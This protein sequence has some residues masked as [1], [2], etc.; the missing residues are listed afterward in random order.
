MPPNPPPQQGPGPTYNRAAIISSMLRYYTLLS[1]AV[2]IPASAIEQAPKAGRSDAS[3]PLQ[4]LL[5]LGFNDKMLD[6]IRHAPFL[7]SNDRPVYYSTCT[8]NYYPHLF[9]FPVEDYAGGDAQAVDMWPV[10]E[11]RVAEGFV[12]LARP[13]Q[14]DGRGYWWLLD[15]GSGEFF[16]FWDGS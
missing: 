7:G 5:L 11:Q 15:T 2:S 16:F 13:L 1:K 3:I 14:G 4:Q 10:P 6:F 9:R 8:L 12:P